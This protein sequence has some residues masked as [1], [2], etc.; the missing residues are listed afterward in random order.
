MPTH[1]RYIRS[2][3]WFDDNIDNIYKFADIKV[4]FAGR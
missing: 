3:M 2:L 4:L 1:E